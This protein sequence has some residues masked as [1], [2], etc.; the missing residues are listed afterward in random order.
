[1]LPENFKVGVQAVIVGT[2]SDQ[3]TIDASNILLKCP[4]KYQDQ[5]TSP[6]LSYTF[7]AIIG[8][9]AIAGT[10]VVTSVLRPFQKS[11]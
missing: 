9:T 5:Q 8:L 1:V 4:S 2:L 7:Y 10:Y 3:R 11:L 6:E